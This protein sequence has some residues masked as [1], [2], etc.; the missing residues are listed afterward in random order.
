MYATIKVS[1]MTGRPLNVWSP[2][3][4]H[5]KLNYM[6]DNP[7]TRKLVEKPR[8]WP[9]SSWRFYFLNDDF[10]LSMDRML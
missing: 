8:D 3:K 1:K 7:V 10:M 4:R 5:E 2:K 6:H 9:W